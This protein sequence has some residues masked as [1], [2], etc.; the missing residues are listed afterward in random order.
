MFNFQTCG[1]GLFVVTAIRSKK[2]ISCSNWKQLWLF[3]DLTA[4]SMLPKYTQVKKKS[5]VAI[6]SQVKK[7]SKLFPVSK[8]EQLVCFFWPNCEQFQITDLRI[9]RLFLKISW[10]SSYFVHFVDNLSLFISIFQI[11]KGDNQ[12]YTNTKQS[13]MGQNTIER[14]SHLRL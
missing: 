5:E 13:E 14:L 9:A 12:K 4:N 3:F 6:R 10:N 7:K 1:L 11:L 2:Q 8:W